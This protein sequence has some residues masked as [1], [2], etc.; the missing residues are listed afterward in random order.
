MN[1]CLYDWLNKEASWPIA[2]Q[3]KDRRE[4]QTKRKGV[5]SMESRG[6]VEERK[7]KSPYCKKEPPHGKA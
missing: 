5:G 4:N 6:D 1:V 3:D 7:M 2:R